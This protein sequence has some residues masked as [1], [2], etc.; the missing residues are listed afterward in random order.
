MARET[1]GPGGR[2]GL[3]RPVTSVCHNLHHHHYHR[4]CQKKKPQ[5]LLIFGFPV[6]RQMAMFLLE[7]VLSLKWIHNFLLFAFLVW[8]SRSDVSTIEKDP[9]CRSEEEAY[10]FPSSDVSR[11]SGK[12]QTVRSFTYCTI[13]FLYN[14]W[15]T[16]SPRYVLLTLYQ[17]ARVKDI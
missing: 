3:L 8:L 7:T 4:Q 1:H 6:N 15:W 5:W 17:Q 2:V 13:R 11:S 9:C 16:T 12:I 14:F 10:L